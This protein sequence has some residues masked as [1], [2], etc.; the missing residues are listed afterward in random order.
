MNVSSEGSVRQFPLW[1]WLM[2]AAILVLGAPVWLHWFEPLTFL[3]INGWGAPVAAH[4]WAGLSFFGNGWGVLGATAPLLVLAPRLM[5]S[6]LCA[7]PFVILFARSGKFFLES[8]RPAMLVDAALIRTVGEP[9][10]FVAMPSGHTM[11]AFAV[12][13]AIYFA[14]AP[15]KRPRYAWLWLLALGVGISRVTVGAHWPGDVVVGISLG[16]FSGMLGH[17]LLAR[18]APEHF[19]LTS[20]T[21]RGVAFLVALSVYHLLCEELGFV[22]NMQLQW[23]VAALAAV[24]LLVFLWRNWQATTAQCCNRV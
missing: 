16:I 15:A 10:F 6:W 1:L 4:V 18:I 9:K 2:P 21:M 5:L 13:C 17:L 11:T 19:A 12:V 8:P 3:T 24:S 22:E 7:A 23:V 20:W 14:I